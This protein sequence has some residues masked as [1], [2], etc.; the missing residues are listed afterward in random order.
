MI[1]VLTSGDCALHDEDCDCVVQRFWLA[2]VLELDDAR[3][4]FVKVWWWFAQKEFGYYDREYYEDENGKRD[5]YVEHIP[6]ATGMYVILVMYFG[7]ICHI[8]LFLYR[9]YMHITSDLCSVMQSSTD[10]S[11]QDQKNLL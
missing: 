7:S 2:Q 1:A 6:V 10:T 11:A 9:Y 5:P 3:K 4:G 8:L